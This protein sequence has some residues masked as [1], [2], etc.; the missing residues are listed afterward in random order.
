[1]LLRITTVLIMLVSLVGV[2]NAFTTLVKPSTNLS[3]SVIIAVVKLI[4]DATPG[5][6]VDSVVITVIKGSVKPADTLAFRF[7]K[8]EDNSDYPTIEPKKDLIRLRGHTV[9][10]QV[11]FVCRPW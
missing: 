3:S 8:I 10:H 1:M 9:L 7:P 2:A 5:E 6:S 4:A 11:F